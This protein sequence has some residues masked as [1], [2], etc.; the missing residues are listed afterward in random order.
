MSDSSVQILGQLQ[1]NLDA[2]TPQERKAA[3]YVIDNAH[4]VGVSSIRD[5]SKNAD[6]KPNTL[7]RLARA[8]GLSGFDELREPFKESIRNGQS[9][10]PD[11]ARWLQEMAKGGELSRLYAEMANSS[12]KN[13]ETTFAGTD[14]AQMDRLAK[15]IVAAKRVFVLG[16]GVYNT[17]AQNF[18][19]VASMAMENIVAIP[20]VGSHLIDDLARADEGDL[21][22]AMTFKPYRTEVLEAV[23]LAKSQ[24]ASIVG[25]T[26]SAAAPFVPKCEEVIFATSETPQFFPSTVATTALLETIMAFIVADADKKTVDSIEK[27]HKRR[28]TMG[29]YFAED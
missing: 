28:L 20:K 22:I 1:Q 23:T 5:L 27:F 26:D 4:L 16:V 18:A 15:R 29:V 11:R 3:A 24:G 6:V 10:F 17:L 14:H 12:L 19:Y 13:I 7:V 2:F 8:I 21:V 9:N 25:V